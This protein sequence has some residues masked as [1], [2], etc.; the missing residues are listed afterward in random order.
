MLVK[1]FKS[2]II[3]WLVKLQ[4]FGKIAINTEQTYSHYQYQ[5]SIHVGAMLKF[6]IDRQF[7][8]NLLINQT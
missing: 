8:D 4:N 6:E 2:I 1:S 7:T 3:L 5:D